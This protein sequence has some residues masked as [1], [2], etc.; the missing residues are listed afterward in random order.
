MT[1]RSI[2]EKRYHSYSAA[3]YLLL[4]DGRGDELITHPFG[5]HYVTNRH[6]DHN[7]RR[8]GVNN[9][10]ILKVYK[11]KNSSNDVFNNVLFDTLNIDI[12]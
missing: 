3:V 2:V 4:F 1:R 7:I 8:G 10:V 6:R 12:E 11:K 5:T 9:S